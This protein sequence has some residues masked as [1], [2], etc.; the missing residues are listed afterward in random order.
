MTS[1]KK[2][3][4]LIVALFLMAGLLAGC[5]NE[6]QP[7]DTTQPTASPSASES[8]PPSEAPNEYVYRMPIVDSPVTITKWCLFEST[9]LTSPNEIKSNIE[10]E[11]RTN[12]HIDYKLASVADM[13]TSFNLIITSGDYPDIMFGGDYTGGY[14][15]AIEDGVF[16]D[17]TDVIDMWMPN[18]KGLMESDDDVR[19]MFYTDSGRIPTIM[20]IT[21]GNPQAPFLGP[22]IRTDL[23][24]QVGVSKIPE[25]YDELHS[26]LSLFKNQLEIPIPLSMNYTGY[27]GFLHTF[28]AGYNIAPGFYNENGVVK[29]GFIEDGFLDYLTMMRDWYAEGLIDAEFYTKPDFVVNMGDLSGGKIGVAENA[30]YTLIDIYAMM[31]GNPDY[32][33]AGMPL[34]KQNVGDT[35]HFR[36]VGAKAS[37]GTA[38]TSAVDTEEKLEIVARWL[39]YGYTEEGYLLN[40]YGIEGES[41]NLVND[42]PVLTDIILKDPEGKQP[43][44]VL[45]LYTGA[46][47]TSSWYDPAREKQIVSQNAWDAAAVW[48]DSSLGDWVMPTITMT[49]EEGTDYSSIYNDIDTYITETVPNFIIGTKS[50]DEYSQFVEKIKS[51]N[52]DYCIEIQQDA[53]YRYLAR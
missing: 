5:S 41:Y 22:V 8:T 1:T 33:L 34:P 20:Q 26:A 27:N 43:G 38:V 19:K 40:S 21:Y 11:K 3:V 4:S 46:L 35:L 47:F 9:Q 16:Q 29:F 44:D 6:E 10:M 36:M 17:L 28:T 25:T 18:V 23:M 2:V 51:M 24:D 7:T 31:S 48:N 13:A 12:V 30:F 42:K 15:K 37:P 45:G 39:D 49:T 53:L 50:L 52:I 32:R 14:D